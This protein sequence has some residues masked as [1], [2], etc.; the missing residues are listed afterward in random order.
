MNVAMARIMNITQEQYPLILELTAM[1][2]EVEI[3]D[4]VSGKRVTATSRIDRARIFT[5]TAPTLTEAL[6]VLRTRCKHASTAQPRE[7]AS[8]RARLN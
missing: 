7:D 4:V 2:Y 8:A 6:R 5:T 1:G 3:D